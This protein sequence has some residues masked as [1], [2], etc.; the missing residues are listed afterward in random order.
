MSGRQSKAARRRAGHKVIRETWADGE[1]GI[2][3]ETYGTGRTRLSWSIDRDPAV[4]L[5]GVERVRAL[6]VELEEEIVLQLRAEGESWDDIG[7][8]MDRTGE[9]VR[10]RFGQADSAFWAGREGQR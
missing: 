8:L 4:A 10:R 5:V 2:R 6:L 9:A 1:F 7:V 3:L